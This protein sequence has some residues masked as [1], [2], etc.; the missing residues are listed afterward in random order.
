MDRLIAAEGGVELWRLRTGNLSSEDRVEAEKRIRIRLILNHLFRTLGLEVTEEEM[1]KAQERLLEAAPQDQRAQMEKSIAEQG[2][3]YLR[4]K[5][6]LLLE[7]VF[8]KFLD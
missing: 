7:K 3:V 4:L 2:E 5:N 6:N 1:Q 8:V